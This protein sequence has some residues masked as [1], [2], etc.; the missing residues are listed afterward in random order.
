MSRRGNKVRQ[1]KRRARN[2]ERQARLNEPDPSYDEPLTEARRQRNIQRFSC[3][4]SR[5]L[6]VRIVSMGITVKA[7]NPEELTRETAK[8]LGELTKGQVP[9]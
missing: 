6:T 5:G 1:R 3:L 8:A 9:S 2:V 4:V 7:S